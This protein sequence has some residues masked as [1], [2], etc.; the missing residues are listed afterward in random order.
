MS[1][2][3]QIPPPPIPAD[4][5]D[6]YERL[7]PSAKGVGPLSAKS[8]IE[9]IGRA[10]AALAA[11]RAR[12]QQQMQ[13]VSV[14]VSTAVIAVCKELESINDKFAALSHPTQAAREESAHG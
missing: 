3:P 7:A 8:F 2:A 9:R 14:I 11:E 12:T 5:R 10:E 6:V 13:D 4:L 1:D